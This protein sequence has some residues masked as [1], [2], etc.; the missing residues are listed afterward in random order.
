M[1]DIDR[2]LREFAAE[3]GISRADLACIV[4][5]LSE[6]FGNIIDDRT[7]VGAAYRDLEQSLSGALA[8]VDDWR[9]ACAIAVSERARAEARVAEL[10]GR[11]DLRHRLAPRRSPR[12][13]RGVLILE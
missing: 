6:R 13:P 11:V 12:V 2:E 3:R 4:D 1:L 5:L 10:E 7:P 8:A 9:R